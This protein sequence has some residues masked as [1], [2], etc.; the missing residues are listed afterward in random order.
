MKLKK[1]ISPASDEIQNERDNEELKK[2][3]E[4]K[5]NDGDKSNINQISNYRT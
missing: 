2:V 5:E 1:K 3:A 4:G